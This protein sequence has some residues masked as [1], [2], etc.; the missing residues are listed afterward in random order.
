MLNICKTKCIYSIATYLFIYWPTKAEEPIAAGMS[1]V[2]IRA[3]P[4]EKRLIPTARNT[5]MGKDAGAMPV[6]VQ[7]RNTDQG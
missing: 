1:N 5:S 4:L 3:R 6:C 7:W 2:Q